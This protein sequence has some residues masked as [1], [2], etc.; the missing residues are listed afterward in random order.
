MVVVLPFQNV[1]A[2]PTRQSTGPAQKAAQ[3]GYFYVGP[4]EMA[5][6]ARSKASLR[7]FGD[8]LNPD[9]VSH[10]L[11]CVPTEAWTKGQV[12]V[13]ESGRDVVRKSGAWFLK[14]TAAEPENLDRQVEELMAQ[15]SSDLDIWST[16]TQ[17]YEVDLFCGWFMEESNEGVSMSAHTLY[18]LGERGIELSLDIYG[19]DEMND[20]EQAQPIIPPDAAR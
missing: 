13:F 16:I 10:L 6:L 2:S 9:E 1:S 8:D 11:G 15:M 18:L 4:K 12:K 19:P 7:I 5:H 3:A 20:S 14:A 17:K